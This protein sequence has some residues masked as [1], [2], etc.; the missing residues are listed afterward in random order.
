[1]E[2][3]FTKSTEANDLKIG[4]TSKRIIVDKVEIASGGTPAPVESITVTPAASNP[5]TVPASGGTLSYTVSTTNIDSWEA[6]SNNDDFVVVETSDGF[7]VV[8]VANESSSPKSATITVSGGS[9]SVEIT[10]NQE[11]GDGDFTVFTYVEEVLH[12]THH[13]SFTKSSR[14]GKKRDFIIRIIY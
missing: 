6:V 9:K 2:F 8:V 12:H 14:S 10:I 3:V 1:M 13:E 5:E 7:N 4:S 11:A